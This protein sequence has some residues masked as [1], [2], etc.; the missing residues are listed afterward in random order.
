MA[1]TGIAPFSGNINPPTFFLQ[2]NLSVSL[3]DLVAR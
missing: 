2:H 1:D 3:E